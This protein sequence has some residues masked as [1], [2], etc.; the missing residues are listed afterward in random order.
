M[1]NYKS[2]WD[3]LESSKCG[4]DVLDGRIQEA[5]DYVNEVLIFE[6]V[7]EY[8]DSYI[9]RTVNDTGVREY[10]YLFNEFHE[11]TRVFLERFGYLYDDHEDSYGGTL[12]DMSVED[13]ELVLTFSVYSFFSTDKDATIDV[14][15]CGLSVHDSP[16]D[17]LGKLLY[18]N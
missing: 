8:V 18:V 9:G 5:Q 12:L 2:V 16:A 15:V 10:E 3:Q 14:R 1:S 4:H 7:M 11:G 17:L 13:R 6:E